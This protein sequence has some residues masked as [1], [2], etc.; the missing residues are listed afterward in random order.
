MQYPLSARNPYNDD[1]HLQDQYQVSLE[2]FSTIAH[3]KCD[4]FAKKNVIYFLILNKCLKVPM[5]YYNSMLPQSQPP[6]IP[7]MHY[8]Q[9]QPEIGQDLWDHEKHVSIF[10][11]MNK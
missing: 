2:Y 7:S 11:L 3:E 9:I 8:S 6:I 5:D 1:M 10:V 4:L